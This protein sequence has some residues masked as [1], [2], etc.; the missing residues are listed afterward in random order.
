MT[1]RDQT[2]AQT[3]GFGEKMASQEELLCSLVDA[4]AAADCDRVQEL[5]VRRSAIDINGESWVEVDGSKRLRE[6]EAAAPA[7]RRFCV[8]PVWGKRR[9]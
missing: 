6:W 1:I 4:C 5:L 8:W 9:C 3:S 7:T 2:I